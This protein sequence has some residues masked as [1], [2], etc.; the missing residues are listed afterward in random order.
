MKRDQG[1]LY[2]IFASQV[3]FDVDNAFIINSSLPVV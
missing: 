3:N 2:L 1:T